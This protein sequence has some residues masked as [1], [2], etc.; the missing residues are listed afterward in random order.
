MCNNDV[1]CKLFLKIGVSPLTDYTV[2]RQL[3]AV[4]ANE[5]CKNSVFRNTINTT[6]NTTFSVLKH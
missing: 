2:I 6:L 1:Y 3:T 5:H 4:F